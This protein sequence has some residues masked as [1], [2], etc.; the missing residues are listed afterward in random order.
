MLLELPGVAEPYNQPRQFLPEVYWQ[1]GYVDMVKAEVIT[2]KGKMSGDRILPF[3]V[4]EE[5]V[6]IDYAEDIIEAEKLLMKR[7]GMS[8]DKDKPSIKRY[9][10]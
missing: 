1:L 6:E 2:K 3:I 5:W 9:A 10:A 7:Q 4:E 8:S